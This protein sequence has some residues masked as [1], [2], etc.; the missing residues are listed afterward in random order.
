MRASF[1]R[2]AFILVVLLTGPGLANA[3]K[4]DKDDRQFLDDVRP[5]LLGDEDKTY[6]GLKE[7]SD[8]LEFQKIFWA[9]RDPDLSTP[10][11][12]YQAEYETARAEADQR[13]RMPAQAGSLTDCGR[14]FILLGKPDEVQQEGGA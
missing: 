4:L 5:I 12:E 1:L 10:A 7:K 8:R 11:N 3:Q 13:Y 2:Y 14:V 9:R 6:K